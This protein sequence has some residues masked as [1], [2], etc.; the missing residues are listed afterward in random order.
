MSGNNLKSRLSKQLNEIQEKIKKSDEEE[1]LRKV[2]Q[3]LELILENR[4][5]NSF[6]VWRK[7]AFSPDKLRVIIDN[8]YDKHTSV[9]TIPSSFI[10]RWVRGKDFT[11]QETTRRFNVPY[12]EPEYPQKFKFARIKVEDLDFTH[13]PRPFPGIMSKE[14]LYER[15]EKM[16][17]IQICPNR[18]GVQLFFEVIKELEKEE[19][20]VVVTPPVSVPRRLQKTPAHEGRGMLEF[21]QFDGLTY[22]DDRAHLERDQ[23]II[24]VLDY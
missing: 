23:E 11:K 2:S 14:S 17:G 21:T 6:S 24:V 8:F 7:M 4:F 15:V 22:Q 12:D 1:Y 19:S 10:Q 3:Q 9:S 20:L 13:K 16:Q 18:V 5:I